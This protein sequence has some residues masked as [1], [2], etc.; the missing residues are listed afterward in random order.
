MLER[1]GAKCIFIGNRKRLAEW[2]ELA[3]ENCSENQSCIAQMLRG[4]Q[5]VAYDSPG[6]LNLEELHCALEAGKQ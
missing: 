2:I 6:T 3:L 5:I 4:K 1:E